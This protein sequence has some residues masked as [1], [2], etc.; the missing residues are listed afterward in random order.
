MAID[1][2]KVPTAIRRRAA[3]HLESIRGTPMAPGAD[4]ASLGS[5]VWP[6][7]RPDLDEVAYYEFSVDL[8]GRGRRLATSAAGLSELMASR[9]PSRTRSRRASNAAV[10]GRLDMTR[11][12][13]FIIVSAAAHDFPVPHWSLD[14]SPVSAQLAAAAEGGGAA[15]DRITKV[16]SLSYVGESKDGSLVARVGQLPALLEGLPHDLARIDAGNGTL[17]AQP[18]TEIRSD[19]KADGVEHE[20]KREAEKPPELKPLEVDDWGVFR[21]RFADA[22]GPYLDDLRRQAAGAWRIEALIDEFGE[23]IHVGTTHRVAL[24]EPEAVVELGGEGASLVKAYIDETT[25]SAALVIDVPEGTDIAQET[26]IDVTV[27]YRDGANERLRFFLVSARTPSNR[28][29]ASN[30]GGQ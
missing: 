1:Q 14:R 2:S 4:G 19:D 15:I 11:D 25:G 9:E 20:E 26:D 12:R 21:E 22:F 23:G 3:Q 27:S 13:G 24:L 16:D 29:T 17:T 28:R 6:I 18:T 5:D 10:I 7:Y 30:E 8:G